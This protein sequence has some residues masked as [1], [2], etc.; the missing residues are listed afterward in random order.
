MLN[1][2]DFYVMEGGKLGD[3]YGYVYDGF[4]TADQLV[5]DSDGKWS[6]GM[7]LIYVKALIMIVKF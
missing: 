7:K 6:T 2:D 4:Y 1:Q 5:L 3:I